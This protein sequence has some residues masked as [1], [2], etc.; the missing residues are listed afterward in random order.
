MCRRS[1][2]LFGIGLLLAGLALAGPAGAASNAIVIP[3]ARNLGVFST[4]P[5]GWGSDHSTAVLAF[6]NYVGPETGQTHQ[7]RSYLWFPLETIPADATVSAAM[8]EVYVDDWPFAG[9][10][11]MGVYRVM[12][13]WDEDFD[14]GTRPAADPM[15]LATAAIQSTAGWRSWDV[16]T[17]VGAW[18]VGKLPN[19]GLMLA[20]AP[21]PESMIGNGWAC[22]GP[23]RTSGDPAHAP[24][25]VVTYTLPPP[26]IPEPATLV[27]AG[28]GLT[29]LWG[30][31]QW[32]GRRTAARDLK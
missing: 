12:I 30:M 14:W 20:G 13:P 15:P 6:G 18:L 17:E 1:W 26:E 3:V 28:T 16:T 9:S 25:L 19:H 11:D 23:G 24:R 32:L 22:A 2:F 7:C 10:G 8:L 4:V 31:G 27:L 21:R 29:V 5:V